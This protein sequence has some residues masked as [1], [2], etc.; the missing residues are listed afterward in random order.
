MCRRRGIGSFTGNSSRTRTAARVNTMAPSKLT[1][2]NAMKVLFGFV[3]DRSPGSRRR[4]AAGV[5]RGRAHGI[6]ASRVVKGGGGRELF[7][8]ICRSTDRLAGITGERSSGRT[9]SRTMENIQ[10]RFGRGDRDSLS[11]PE[12]RTLRPVGLENDRVGRAQDLRAGSLREGRDVLKGGRSRRFN[13]T[14]ESS[15]SC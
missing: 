2:S 9:T 12:T 4:Y 7:G 14:A 5:E 1:P 15:S 10:P 6:S 3:G 8:E 13:R 11:R